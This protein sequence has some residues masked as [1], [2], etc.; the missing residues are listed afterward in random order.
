MVRRVSR[1]RSCREAVNAENPEA[2]HAEKFHGSYHHT[3]GKASSVRGLIQVSPDD[4]SWD[5]LGIHGPDLN[6]I[7]AH[8]GKPASFGAPRCATDS[9]D[10]GRGRECGEPECGGVEDPGMSVEGG[11]RN[12]APIRA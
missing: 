12:M 5:T 2:R 10:E 3:K 6:A 7:R 9:A 1:D 4:L 11:A 8:R